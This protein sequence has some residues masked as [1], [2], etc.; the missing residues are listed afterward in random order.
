MNI[1]YIALT[2]SGK[3]LELQVCKS[4]A[5]FYVGTMDPM[6]GPVSRESVEYYR[7]N[8]EAHSALINNTFTQRE[9]P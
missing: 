1:G 5:G 3:E 8:D 9:Y 6:L 2:F 7:T 4:A